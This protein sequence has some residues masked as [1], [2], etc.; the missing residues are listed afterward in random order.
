MI[1]GGGRGIGEAVA[2]ELAEQGVRVLVS[3]RSVDEIEA[4]AGALQEAGHEAF[5]VACDVT[6]P[7]QVQALAAQ[8]RD[9]LGPVDILVNNAGIAASAPLRRIRLEDWNQIFAVNVTGTFLCTQAFLPAMVEQ[10]WGR[11]VNVA[12]IAGLSGAAYISVYA[13]SK[14]AVVGFT[15][16]IAAE[17]AAYGVTVNAVCP[18]YVD[19]AMVSQSVDRIVAK[20]GISEEKARA[21]IVGM[22]PQ[23]RVLDPEEV[24]FQVVSLCDPRARGVNGQTLVLDGGGLL[25]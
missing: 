3:A 21:S 1:T 16:C 9:L 14:H 13:A 24:A 15:R 10:K 17:V 19:T 4:V 22:N 23:E 7:D 12:S 11:V 6:Q 20:T 25:S 8:A 5:A 2:R 18:G